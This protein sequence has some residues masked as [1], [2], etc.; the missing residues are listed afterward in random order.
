[1]D[2]IIEKLL[3]E[4]NQK[5]KEI[6]KIFG[7]LQTLKEYGANF[8]L[9]DIQTLIGS[10]EQTNG[11]TASITIKPDEF[12]GLSQTEA[13]EKYLRMIGHA[14]PF[15]DIFQ[16]LS[17]GGVR[18]SSTGRASLN[19]QLTRATKKFAKIG[20]GINVSFGLL[21]WY[22]G[23]RRRVTGHLTP[24]IEDE[25]IVTEEIIEEEIKQEQE[26]SE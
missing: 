15:E 8:D 20:K 24:I 13:A 22:P 21:E 18:F 25:D 10:G 12:Y 5:A 19:I 14:A 3:G 26:K 6:A 23:R 7:T 9:P 16:A 11:T 1:M 17:D 2:E 4:L